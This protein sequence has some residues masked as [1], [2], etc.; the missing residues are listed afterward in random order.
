MTGGVAVPLPKHP[1]VNPMSSLTENG[2]ANVRV[3][4]FRV[5]GDDPFLP[6]I[7]SCFFPSDKKQYSGF[8][9]RQYP[10]GSVLI[11]KILKKR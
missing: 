6:E 11:W 8:L 10:Y 5:N 9:G 7:F 1:H 3:N 2:L 4:T